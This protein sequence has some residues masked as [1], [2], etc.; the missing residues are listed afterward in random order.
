MGKKIK[1]TTEAHINE[2]IDIDYTV[3]VAD[4]D[5]VE[6]V[7]HLRHVGYEVDKA[8][9]R[10]TKGALSYQTSVQDAD[11]LYRH[12]CD[13]CGVNYFTPVNELL[14]AIKE[15]ILP[16]AQIRKVS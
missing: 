1:G 3:D 14:A 2:W 8:G 16:V 10:S 4:L 5:E 12:L 13:K 11:R 9:Y 7:E 6:L 15:I